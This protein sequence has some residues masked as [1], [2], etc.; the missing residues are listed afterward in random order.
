MEAN[1]ERVSR[2]DNIY[3][4]PEGLYTN[5]NKHTNHIPGLTVRRIFPRCADRRSAKSEVANLVTVEATILNAFSVAICK[6]KFTTEIVHV[7]E[8]M[9]R[10]LLRRMR[11]SFRGRGHDN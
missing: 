4:N 1:G 7:F 3:C 2:L 10:L 8:T 9:P 5:S 6:S 11:A